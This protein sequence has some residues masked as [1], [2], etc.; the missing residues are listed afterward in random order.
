MVRWETHPWPSV[1]AVQRIE[2]TTVQIEDV[3]KKMD[4][5]EL[6]V[7]DMRKLLP[8]SLAPHHVEDLVKHFDKDKSGTID[9]HELAELLRV[10]PLSAPITR[11]IPLKDISNRTRIRSCGLKM[12]RL[13]SFDNIILLLITASSVMLAMET[14]MDNPDSIR[15]GT[16]R[17]RFSCTTR[18]RAMLLNRCGGRALR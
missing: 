8:H 14:P 4:A 12:L 3:M 2:W 10:S 13:L 16:Y 11:D 6:T 15:L 18:Q 17:T 1:Y 5:V 9:R 7:S